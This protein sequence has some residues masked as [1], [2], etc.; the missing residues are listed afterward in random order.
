MYIHWKKY[1]AQLIDKL[2]EVKD[3]LVLAGDGR[4]DSM[5]H[6]AKFGAYTIFCCCTSAIIH[7]NLVQVILEIAEVF[8]SVWPIINII[9]ISQ[10]VHLFWGLIFQTPLALVVR[11]FLES[12]GVTGTI[13]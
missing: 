3:P 4:H 1:Q 10:N 6:S 7:F 5:G 2:K 9:K 11:V 12:H 13:N 8:E